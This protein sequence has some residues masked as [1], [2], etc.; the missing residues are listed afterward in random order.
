MDR[1]PVLYTFGT[2][3]LGVS[4]KG[5]VLGQT[6]GTNV[7]VDPNN[8]SR[9][10]DHSALWTLAHEVR[11]ALGNDTAHT[12]YSDQPGPEKE[13]AGG[14][15]APITTKRALTKQDVRYWWETAK[16][17]YENQSRQSRYHNPKELQRWHDIAEAPFPGVTSER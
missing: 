9:H 1:S 4:S 10:S 17:Y 13:M 15:H 2:A 7:L 8:I 6:I 12:T 14:L 5:Y 3:E 16:D 11:H